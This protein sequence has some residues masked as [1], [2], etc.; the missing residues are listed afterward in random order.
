MSDAQVED[1]VLADLGGATRWLIVRYEDGDCAELT[2][3]TVFPG[4]LVW[5]NRYAAQ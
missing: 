5:L 1:H 4:R 2:Q 3:F